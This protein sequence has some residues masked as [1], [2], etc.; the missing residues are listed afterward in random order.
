MSYQDANITPSVDYV[1]AE[2]YSLQIK[3]PREEVCKQPP[4]KKAN[5]TKS[6]DQRNS[7]NINSF[8]GSKYY[9]SSPTDS[10]QANNNSSNSQQSKRFVKA[11]RVLGNQQNSLSS[12]QQQQ[13]VNKTFYSPK[14]DRSQQQ[15]QQS[16]IFVPR[17]GNQ[18][19]RNRALFLETGQQQRQQQ[20]T[21]PTQRVQP[22]Y[23]APPSNGDKIKY[24]LFQ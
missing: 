3:R 21:A 24:Q 7:S 18:S 6:T 8:S 23:R 17:Q 20:F 9:K 1:T 16:Q 5:V 14:G 19:N 22:Q 12:P 10:N 13:Q 2:L 4:S 11:R 15:Q